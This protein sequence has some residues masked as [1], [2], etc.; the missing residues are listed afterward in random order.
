M[1]VNKIEYKASMDV[2][3]WLMEEG[4]NWSSVSSGG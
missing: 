4:G 3:F 2:L 1:A